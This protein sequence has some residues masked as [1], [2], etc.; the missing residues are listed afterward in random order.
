MSTPRMSADGADGLVDQ[1]E[2]VSIW[3][4]SKYLDAVGHLTGLQLPIS[5]S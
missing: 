3:R 4:T 5:K 1:R 2:N